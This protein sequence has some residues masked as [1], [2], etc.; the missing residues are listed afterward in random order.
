[1]S[2]VG[3][4]ICPPEGES[5]G[6]E[7]NLADRIC[8][9]LGILVAYRDN[10]DRRLQERLVQGMQTALVSGVS[11]RA[12]LGWILCIVELPNVVL[13]MSRELVAR[14]DSLRKTPA[15][16]I[17][18]FELSSTLLR[19]PNL[20]AQFRESDFLHVFNAL[21]PATDHFSFTTFIV[22]VGHH[23]IYRWF[24]KVPINLR[25]RIAAHIRCRLEAIRIAAD[26]KGPGGDPQLA[27]DESL[28]MDQFLRHYSFTNAPA[29]AD[30]PLPSCLISLIKTQGTTKHWV[31]GNRVISIS[32]VLQRGFLE[33]PGSLCRKCT[34]AASQPSSSTTPS[35]S[36]HSVLP[37]LDPALSSIVAERK[38]H[39]SAVQRPVSRAPLQPTPTSTDDF[40][41]PLPPTPA[42]PKPDLHSLC[43]CWCR[44]YALI[45]I[46]H[47]FGK[48]FWVVE[49]NGDLQ[50]VSA[51]MRLNK[52]LSARKAGQASSEDVAEVTGGG[53]ETGGG[54]GETNRREGEANKREGEANRL[55]RRGSGQ[56]YEPLRINVGRHSDV[57]RQ[58]GEE[59][60][61]EALGSG[62]SSVSGS[63][64]SAKSTPCP[65]T[66]EVDES[67]TGLSQQRQWT[68]A[69]DSEASLGLSPDWIFA[70]L[71]PGW[72]A[73]ERTGEE[74][75]E[76]RNA[77]EGVTELPWSGK[78]G[79]QVER[80]L[81]NLDRLRPYEAHTIGVLYA[82]PKQTTEAAML[83]NECGTERYMRFLEGLGKLLPLKGGAEGKFTAGLDGK[84]KDGLFTY[85]WTDPIT[86]VL[87]HVATLMPTREGDREQTAKKRLIGN[88][89]V[90]IVWNDS[91]REYALETLSGK[92]A[93]VA[94]V[95][96]PL[97]QAT[98]S[99][100]L[101][102]RPE[103]SRW[104]SLKEA[105]VSDQEA[106]LLCRQIGM[107][108]EF[109]AHCW[110][111]G[112]SHSASGIRSTY[113]SG[114]MERL[115]FIRQLRSRFKTPPSTSPPS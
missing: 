42:T 30:P 63:Y 102:A 93:F 82:G 24:L 56:S 45:E 10:L 71:F 46:R 108:A 12:V 53:E 38:R 64:A 100:R 37:T 103:I 77:G 67:E 76:G 22:A 112:Q 65:R 72:T 13:G 40:H 105:V 3:E 91:G 48:S 16:I 28:L 80:S 32:A 51:I 78:E 50:D 85:H 52:L 95:V 69:T 111:S 104:L 57:G 27:A 79:G 39:Q 36:N 14:L 81:V 9:S 90:T 59:G 1:M 70:Q 55:R 97:H 35:A 41:I 68:T 43:A 49:I 21:L 25:P 60:Q 19:L 101:L 8:P 58:S 44:G 54:E 18:V 115:H 106:P 110:Q 2:Q 34:A 6:A 26:G 98:L 109:S 15:M 113:I 99:M 23:L 7:Q 17:P 86:Q 92:F 31:Q 33:P 107:R 75:S 94:I 89:F 20:Y 74:R 88:D 5:G 11:F 83:G 114:A 61:E 66:L 4:L 84:G 29:D 96:T 62:D 73:S 47:C 87:F